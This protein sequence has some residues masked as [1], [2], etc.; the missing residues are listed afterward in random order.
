MSV[1]MAERVG[2]RERERERE[3]ESEVLSHSVWASVLRTQI[4]AAVVEGG[5]E[6]V[7]SFLE[8]KRIQFQTLG[9]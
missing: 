9:G 7:L 1:L 2:G 5:G 8:F 6:A 4:K 3:R